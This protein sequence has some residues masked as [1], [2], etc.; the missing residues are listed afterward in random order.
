MSKLWENKYI[1]TTLKLKY[2]KIKFYFHKTRK[3]N[4]ENSSDS[5]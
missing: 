4:Y 5:I 3:N 1:G 2:P